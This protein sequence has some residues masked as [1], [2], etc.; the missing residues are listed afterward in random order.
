MVDDENTKMVPANHSMPGFYYRQSG[1]LRL[2]VDMEYNS[3]VC[4]RN[5][6]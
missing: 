4:R 1:A 3:T 5:Y 6:T 2:T